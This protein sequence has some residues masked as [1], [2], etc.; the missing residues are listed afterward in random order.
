MELDAALYTAP[1]LSY[2]AHWLTRLGPAEATLLSAA[3]QSR[4]DLNPHQI[5]AALFALRG[6]D[7]ASAFA[8]GVLLADEVGLGKTIEAGLVLAQHWAAKKRRLLLVVPASLRKQWQLELDDKFSLNATVLDAQSAKRAGGNA[9]DGD[10]IVIVSYEFAALRANEIAAIAWDLVVF[11]EAHR[12]RSLHKDGKRAKALHAALGDRQKILLTAT[13]FQNSLVELWSLVNFID[14]DYLGDQKSFELQYRG[15][16]AQDKLADLSKRLRPICQ[17][18][19]RRQ[20]KDDGQISF[21]NR[22]A[23]TFDFSPTP[24]EA[25]LYEQ[26]SG[27][28]Q[29]TGAVAFPS[30]ARHLVTLVMRKILASSS[31]AIDATLGTV[32]ARLEKREK[33][34]LAD[35]AAQETTQDSDD[36]PSTGLPEAIEDAAKLRA[37]LLEIQSFRDLAGRIERNAKGDALLIALQKAFASNALLP[38]SARKAVIFTE[39]VRTQSYL[40]DLLTANG[41]AGRIVLMNGKNTDPSSKAIFKEWKQRHA[42]SAR[43]SGSPSADMKAAIVEAFRDDA[44]ILIA[45]ESGAEGI[46]L[47]FCQILVNYDLPWNPQRIEQRIGRVHRYGQKCDVFVVNL[48]NTENQVDKLVYDILERKLKLFE[49]VF[50]ASDQVLGAVAAGVDLESRIA[51]ILSIRRGPE[52]IE[53]EFEKLRTELDAVIQET[54]ARTRDLVLSNFDADVRRLLVDRRSNTQLGL[55][56]RQMHWLAFAQGALGATLDGSTMILP[57]G[58]FAADWSK[59]AR[60]DIALVRAD[61]SPFVEALAHWRNHS[62]NGNGRIRFQLAQ[63]SHNFSDLNAFVGQ[64]GVLQVRLL[65]TQS[66]DAG[67]HLLVCA[68]TLAGAPL[69]TDSAARLLLV[70]GTLILQAGLDLNLINASAQALELSQFAE[71]DAQNRR[72]FEQE[73]D[74]LDR[75]GDDENAARDLKVKALEA[76]LK[77]ARKAMRATEAFEARV[78]IKRD[79]S[80][81]ESERDGALAD[82]YAEKKRIGARIDALV[83]TA[84]DRIRLKPEITTLFTVEWELVA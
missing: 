49:G 46:N 33:L 12:L 70:P 47:Q 65:R 7:R 34:A 19:L 56:A 42:G 8:K 48:V 58:R 30:N 81:L 50:G 27:W 41:Y 23:L 9:F 59:A 26:V 29:N 22:Y 79:I 32:M 71:L 5:E 31:F 73:S 62:A 60:L 53:A 54:D 24:E 64:S 55:D 35:F 43:I 13:P 57:Q 69:H 11:D 4:V 40:R 3:A 61:T 44:E 68:C 45:T 25:Q 77:E 67:E 72:W 2:F 78:H 15:N 66:L 82:Y 16:G 14:K 1:Q 75:W 6:T 10:S 63:S 21:T 37:E 38:G 39:S 51:E 84:L 36:D 17:R 52:Q 74:R 80:R 76:Q 28:L 83:D 18:M 20:V